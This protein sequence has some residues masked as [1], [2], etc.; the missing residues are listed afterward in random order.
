MCEE[1]VSDGLF[2]KSAFIKA[3]LTLKL[4]ETYC[5]SQSLMLD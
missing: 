3:W 1:I 2:D 4:W 5:Y